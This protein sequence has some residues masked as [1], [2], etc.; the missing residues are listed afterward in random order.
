MQIMKKIPL[1]QNKEALV[2]D[3]DFDLLS[4]LNWCVASNGYVVKR[5][6]GKIVCLHRYIMNPK[7]KEW[8]DHINHDKLDN[9]RENLRICTASQN[10]GNSI[11]TKSNTSSIYKGVCWD[12]Q[13][14][15]WR[16]L[17]TI[18]YKLIFI[19]LFKEEFHAAMAYDI[20]AKELFGEFAKLNFKPI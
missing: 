17:I 9:R 4:K 5:I 19:G 18:N 3:E 15:L 2:D 10:S 20:W 11:K 7:N 1:T 8:I 6:K 13:M 12:K 16:C 14:K